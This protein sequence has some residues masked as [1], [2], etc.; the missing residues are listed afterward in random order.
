MTETRKRGGSTKIPRSAVTK[1]TEKTETGFDPMAAST[2]KPSEAVL[3]EAAKV[4]PKAEVK[5]DPN[6]MIFEIH[7]YAEAYPHM[8]EDIYNAFKESI[9]KQGLHVPIIVIPDET[10][11]GVLQVIDGRHRY[12]ALTELGMPIDYDIYEGPIDEESLRE[13]VESQNV[14]RRDLSQGQRAMSA[15]KLY[16][17]TMGRPK[18]GD[19]EL[20]DEVAEEIAKR[21]G[22]SVT[23]FRRAVRVNRISSR[24]PEF[25]EHVFEGRIELA[26]AYDMVSDFEQTDTRLKRLNITVADFKKLGEAPSAIG[27]ILRRSKAAAKKDKRDE[28]DSKLGEIAEALP[29]DE[30]QV[31]Y[32]DPPWKFEVRSEQGMDRSAENHYPTMSLSDIANNKPAFAKQGVLFLWTTI[33]H[34]KQAMDLIDI[35][36]LEYKS[37]LIWGKDRE[38]TGYWT[39]GKHEILLIAT[40]EA[41]FNAPLPGD[42]LP[43]FQ[44]LPLGKHSEKPPEF[45]KWIEETYPTAKKLEMYCR[46]PRDG[47]D[48]WGFESD[49]VS[50]IDKEVEDEFYDSSK[51]TGVDAGPEDLDESFTPPE[52]LTKN[53]DP[54]GIE[55]EPPGL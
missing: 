10:R 6:G 32:A 49:G 14:H 39:R 31:V 18:K 20:G 16:T 37:H 45:A 3:A 19:P 43:S 26:P 54:L 46:A 52:F 17:G 21:N 36:G 25:A 2:T 48:V 50:I 1:K 38:I 11:D 29:E 22:I 34:L 13:Y 35:W 41:G 5:T 23:T 7:P 9:A 8:A 44:I 24:F 30:Y 27:E 12:N 4:T 42:Q 40:T 33:P 15:A 51:D 28:R 53:K 55:D 47:W